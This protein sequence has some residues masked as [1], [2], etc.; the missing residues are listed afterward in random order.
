MDQ[1][2]SQCNRNEVTK[3]KRTSDSR[4]ILGMAFEFLHEFDTQLIFPEEL[5]AAPLMQHGGQFEIADISPENSPY[6]WHNCRF[7]V[8]IGREVKWKAEI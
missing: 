3:R 7:R 2:D 5:T 1:R 6:Q 8:I 4:K